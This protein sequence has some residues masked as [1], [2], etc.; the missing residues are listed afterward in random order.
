M[1]PIQRLIMVKNRPDKASFKEEKKLAK[2]LGNYPEVN[3]QSLM[4]EFRSTT[5][6]ENI[7]KVEIK[8]EKMTAEKI[9]EIFV[10]YL[11]WEK[12]KADRKALDFFIQVE[13]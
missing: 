6:S 13:G 2:L 8:S 12:E 3:F 11:E 1:S 5:E 10:K 7:E 9:S 4:L